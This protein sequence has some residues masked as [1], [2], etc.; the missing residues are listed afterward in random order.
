MGKT[1]NILSKTLQQIM[2]YS[3]S[4]IKQICDILLHEY[5]QIIELNTNQ[6]IK[7]SSKIIQQLKYQ[8]VYI[9]LQKFISDANNA[10]LNGDTFLTITGMMNEKFYQLFKS[11]NARENIE[12][13]FFHICDYW[14]VPEKFKMKKENN[15]YIQIKHCRYEDDH[16]ASESM[17][18]YLYKNIFHRSEDKTLEKLVDNAVLRVLDCNAWNKLD[19]VEKIYDDSTYYDAVQTI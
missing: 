19:F 15:D 18:T 7:I 12:R 2:N 11:K 1:D 16:K 13:L 10:K 4:E 8:N 17:P 9:N 3:M 14:N 5:I 6:F